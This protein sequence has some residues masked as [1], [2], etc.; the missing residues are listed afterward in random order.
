MSDARRKAVSVGVGLTIIAGT[1]GVVASPAY[2]TWAS[3][4][5]AR[6]ACLFE[7]GGG[8]GSQY[9]TATAIGNYELGGWNGDNEI[10]S[11]INYTPY[12]LNLYDGDNQSGASMTIWKYTGSN[13][14]QVEKMS[15]GDLGWNDR[16]E[17]WKLF[18]C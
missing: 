14:G 12:C 13:A 6:Q 11:A 18:A 17:S 3:C 4:R 5:N 1:I 15:L 2:A 9:G 7:D 16:A 10:S 8:G